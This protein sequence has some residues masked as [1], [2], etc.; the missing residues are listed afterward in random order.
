MCTCFHYGQTGHYQSE[1][2][3][4]ICSSVG[5]SGSRFRSGLDPQQQGTGICGQS[6]NQGSLGEHLFV[7]GH[8][9]CRLTKQRMRLAV[10]TFRVRLGFCYNSGGCSSYP[11]CRDKYFTYVLVM[12][13]MCS[14]IQEPHTLL[15]LMIL[16]HMWV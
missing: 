7:L 14:L 9:L 11:K 5:A 15:Y 6:F 4:L 16:L 2:P 10:M 12:S 1:F 8:S 3:F 13:L